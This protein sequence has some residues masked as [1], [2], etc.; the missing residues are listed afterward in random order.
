MKKICLDYGHGNL[1]GAS[2]GGYIEDR[3]IDITGEEC[4]KVLLE[5]GFDVKLTRKA[6]G[7]SIPLNKRCEISNNYGA[8]LFISIHFNA[9]GGTGFE[10]IRTV[11]DTSVTIPICN[12]IMLKLTSLHH[13][14]RPRRVYTRIGSENK[15]YYG[16]L[17]GTRCPA[18]ILE[19]AFIDNQTD[20][21]IFKNTENLKKLGRI[22]AESIIEFY[23]CKV[24]PSAVMSATVDKPK[25]TNINLSYEGKIDP[26][27]DKYTVG[28]LSYPSPTSDI[29]YT[30]GIGDKVNL[31][32]K[33]GKYW[34]ILVPNDK[35]ETGVGFI[36]SEYIKVIK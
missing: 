5:N 14:I 35:N 15:D 22:Y 10:A 23:G 29:L 27:G 36:N 33:S 31:L 12:K 11:R 2:Y 17:R 34:G 28:V 4:R 32:Y 13:N 6:G 25:E 9:G 21:N 20:I 16:V 8:N 1:S 18:M 24:K 7:S 19:G 3:W 30:L 26:K